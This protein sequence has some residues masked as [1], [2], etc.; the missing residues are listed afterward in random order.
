MG[1]QLAGEAVFVP[2]DPGRLGGF[3]L[4]NLAGEAANTEIEL[5]LPTVKS[6]RRRVVPVRRVPLHEGIPALLAL[7]RDAASASPKPGARPE[8]SLTRGDGHWAPERGPGTTG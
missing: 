7:D 5:V 1:S 6:V 3:V 4:Y 8:P 2:G